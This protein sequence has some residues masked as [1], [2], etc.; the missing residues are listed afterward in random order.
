M[1]VNKYL[2][3]LLGCILALFIAMFISGYFA[4][5]WSI[6]FWIWYY[7]KEDITKDEIEIKSKEEEIK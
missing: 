5:C 6:I 2:L 4:I 7:N 3:I 1:Y